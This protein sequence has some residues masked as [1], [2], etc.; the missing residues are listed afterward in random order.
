[1]NR[2]NIILSKPRC[3]FGIK[4]G[5]VRVLDKKAA[6]KIGKKWCDT[7]ARPKWKKKITAVKT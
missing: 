6:E 5:E 7:M 3:L 1:M 4:L 2:Y